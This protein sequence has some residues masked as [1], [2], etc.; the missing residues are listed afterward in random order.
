[1]KVAAIV[2]L[3]VCASCLSYGEEAR[4]NLSTTA[5]MPDESVTG[6]LQKIHDLTER[7]KTF[8][9]QLETKIRAVLLPT[10]KQSYGDFTWK[11]SSG[12]G[13]TSITA[14]D[15]EKH[16]HI[17]IQLEYH[18]TMTPQELK[19]FHAT[20]LG[21]PAKRFPNKWVWVL[22]GRTELRFGLCDTSLE[23]DATLDA[24][25]KSFNLEALKTL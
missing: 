11:C 12:G 14:Y 17:W 2:S 25:V 4:T 15:A 18:A 6:L 21:Y 24:I 3:L 22:V 13:F 10:G 19:A 16:Q 8:Q 20:C 9:E 5:V 1:M 23:S 7:Q